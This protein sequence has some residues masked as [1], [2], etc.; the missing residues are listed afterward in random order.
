MATVYEFPTKVQLPKHVKERLYGIAWDYVD[1]LYTALDNL[2][3]DDYSD[4]S[5][6][7]IAELVKETLA[8]GLQDAIDQY[9]VES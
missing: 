4:E 3:D 8:E 5:M 6:F 2:S 9:D 1:A 7:E